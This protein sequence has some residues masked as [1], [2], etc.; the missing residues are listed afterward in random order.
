[1]GHGHGNHGAPNTHTSEMPEMHKEG[2]KHPQ[3]PTSHAPHVPEHDA[4]M[5]KMDH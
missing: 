4:P 2:E 1:M 5:I 3:Q